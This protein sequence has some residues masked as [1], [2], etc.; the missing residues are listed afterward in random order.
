MAQKGIVLVVAVTLAALL[1]AYLQHTPAQE[2]SEQ[3]TALDTT[4][5]FTDDFASFIKANGKIDATQVTLPGTSTERTS[6]ALPSAARPLP[7]TRS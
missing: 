4:C 6:S 3:P 5:G 7:R 1:A 2:L